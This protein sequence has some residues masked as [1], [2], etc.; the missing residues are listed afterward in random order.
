MS[1]SPAPSGDGLLGLED[2]D[3][4]GVV[5][6]REPD[7]GADVERGEM[8]VRP[9]DIGGR[10]ADRGGVVRE[11]LL[12]ELADILPGGDGFELGVVDVAVDFLFLHDKPPFF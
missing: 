4:G 2:L 6:E 7:D 9:R 8:L 5:S 12:A 3:G 1:T 10:D 11:R